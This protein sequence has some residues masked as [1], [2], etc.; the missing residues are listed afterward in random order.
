MEVKALWASS[1]GLLWETDDILGWGRLMDVD[2]G[3]GSADD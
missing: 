3:K 1:N 2:D